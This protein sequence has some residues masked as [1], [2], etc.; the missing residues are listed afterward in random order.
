M[1]KTKTRV[2]NIANSFV[3]DSLF[4][5]TTKHAKTKGKNCM[6]KIAGNPVDRYQ[7][8]AWTP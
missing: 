8:H 3:W 4:F 1:V 5:N 2:P 7:C 6:P